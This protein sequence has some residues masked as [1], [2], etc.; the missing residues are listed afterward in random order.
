[1]SVQPRSGSDRKGNNFPI[2]SPSVSNVSGG[3]ITAFCLPAFVLVFVCV[4]P[5]L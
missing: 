5:E 1:M 3:T 2:F 4:S